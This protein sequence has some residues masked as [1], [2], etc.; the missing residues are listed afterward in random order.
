MLGS[1]RFLQPVNLIIQMVTNHSVTSV[2]SQCT[3]Q[4]GEVRFW[5]LGVRGPGG[6]GI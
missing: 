4:E 5:V 1:Q 3:M 2:L 6:R